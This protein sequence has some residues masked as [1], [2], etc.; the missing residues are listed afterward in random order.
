MVLIPF[1]GTV[2]GA[3]AVFFI[4]RSTNEKLQKLFLGFASGVML[5]ASVWSLLLPAIEGGWVPAAVG[6]VLGFASMVGLDEA[7]PK[8]CNSKGLKLS[9][10]AMLIL[11]VTLHNLPEGMAVGAAAAGWNGVDPG[12]MAKLFVLSTGIG[13]QNIPE[14]AI[15]SAPLAAN[16]VNKARAF[17][18]GALS[19]A[20]EPL[21]AVITLLLTA[22]ITPILPYIL[23]FAA[24]TM[25][26]VVFEELTPEMHSGTKSRLAIAGVALGFT[27]M[28][29]LDVTLG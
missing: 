9:P 13:V 29:V 23:A 25:V 15:I 10:S 21:G 6:F 2:L 26:Y 14:G 16:G 4:R 1:I 12:E 27:L 24:G 3:A 8:I 19:G 18:L 17:S 7:V 20:V 28:M 22:F 11:A 5:A